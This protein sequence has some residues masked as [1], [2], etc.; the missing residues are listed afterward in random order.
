MM[1]GWQYKRTIAEQDTLQHTWQVFTSQ[2]LLG[3]KKH[4][5]LHRSRRLLGF[6]TLGG[7]LQHVST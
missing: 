6:E 4:H 7:R 5:L 3:D 1:S 2:V